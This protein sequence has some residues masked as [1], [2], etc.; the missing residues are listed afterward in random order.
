MATV[1]KRTYIEK[2]RIQHNYYVTASIYALGLEH[3][4]KRTEES[5]PKQYSG[6]STNCI[7]FTT[8]NFVFPGGYIHSKCNLF[9]MASSLQRTQDRSA[10]WPLCKGSTIL[11]NQVPNDWVI[12]TASARGTRS[13]FINSFYVSCMLQ[14]WHLQSRPRW[15]HLIRR[16]LG[17][18]K[19]PTCLL[20]QNPLERRS[21]WRGLLLFF[22]CHGVVSNCTMIL[23]WWQYR[24]FDDYTKV[25]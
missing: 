14:R 5:C 12:Y 23:F 16:S 17:F 19:V 1:R 2:Q 11:S 8:A 15:V 18:I 10:S 3:A 21:R 13:V 24:F 9:T 6:I 25:A 22:I 7:C 4:R 20:T